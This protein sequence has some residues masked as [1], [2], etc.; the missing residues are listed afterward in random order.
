M[1]LL[2]PFWGLCPASNDAAQSLV[3]PPYDVLSREEA[4]RLGQSSEHSFLHVSRAEI[5]LPEHIDVNDPQVYQKAKENFD[6]L[7]D[8]SILQKET[9][10]C[11][12]VYQI[13]LQGHTQRGLIAAVSTEAYVQGLVKRHELTRPSKENDRVQQISAL[14]VHTGPVLLAYRSQSDID[15]LLLELSQ[16]S[17]PDYRVSTPDLATHSVW[18]ISA[19]PDIEVLQSA[20]GDLPALYIADGH[21]RAAAASRLF[22]ES[23]RSV[24]CSFLAVIFPHRQLKVLDYNRVVRDLNGLT[25][26]AFLKALEDSFDVHISEHPVRPEH[27]HEFGLYL[28]GKWFLLTLKKSVLAGRNEVDRLDAS[29][30]QAEVFSRLLDIHNPRTDERIQFIGGS[31]G[32]SGLQK[33]VDSGVMK[34]AFSMFPT[35]MDDVMAIADLN[36]EMPPKSTWFEPKLADGLVSLSIHD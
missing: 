12:Y 16:R 8:Q 10:L 19:A 28:D 9:N 27:R 31:R 3:S 13:E 6:K 21:H 25:S 4:Y 2:K 11:F 14:G 20:C 7:F 18:R 17:A 1:I 36:S 32:L 15:L 35:P 5:D 23:G 33:E 22:L 29:L 30:L 26:D 24:S 34:A